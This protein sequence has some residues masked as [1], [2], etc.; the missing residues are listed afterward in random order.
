MVSVP[1]RGQHAGAGRAQRGAVEIRPPRL[2]PETS[3]F[4]DFLRMRTRF[5]FP[6]DLQFGGMTPL[7]ARFK[8]ERPIKFT[9]A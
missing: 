3:D 7:T 4:A 6:G 1:L 8:K 9:N 5:P 2:Q